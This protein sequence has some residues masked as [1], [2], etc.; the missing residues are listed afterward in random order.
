MSEGYS[1]GMCFGFEDRGGRGLKMWLGALFFV[2][3][4]AYALM[5]VVDDGCL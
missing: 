2:G 4:R 1:V 3:G 5:C